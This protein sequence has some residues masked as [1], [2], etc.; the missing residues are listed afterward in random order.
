MKTSS[1]I[2]SLIIVIGVILA[3]ALAGCSGTLT[4]EEKAKLNASI[5]KERSGRHK[6][7]ND[8]KSV[9]K[10][11]KAGRRGVGVGVGSPR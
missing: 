6:E 2:C 11:K 4:P 7:L 8:A 5:Q 3:P 10:S 9:G 1:F